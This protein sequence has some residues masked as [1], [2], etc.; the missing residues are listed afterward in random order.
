[1]KKRNRIYL[2]VN[3]CIDGMNYHDPAA[4]CIISSGRILAVEEERFIGIK[5][6]PGVF[7]SNALEWCLQE[8]G[9]TVDDVCCVAVPYSPEAAERRLGIEL[10]AGLSY[11]GLTDSTFNMTRIPEP[12]SVRKKVMTFIGSASQILA[13]YSRSAH[14]RQTAALMSNL[15]TLRAP[16]QFIPHHLAHAASAY[17]LAWP[18][19]ALV[20]VLDGVGEYSATSIFLGEQHGLTLLH[21]EPV[22]NSLGY[23]YASAT[24]FLGFHPWRDEGKTMAMAAYGK[25]NSRIRDALGQVLQVTPDGWQL[26]EFFC[27]LIHDGLMLDS[28][29][30]CNRLAELLQLKPMCADPFMSQAY[31]DFAWQVQDLLTNAVRSLVRRWIRKTDL[32]TVCAAGGVFLNSRMNQT[33]RE[34]KDVH[35]LLVQPVARDSGLAIGA[36]L[37]ASEHYNLLEELPEKIFW[38]GIGPSFN[39]FEVGNT[40][41]RCGCRFRQEVSPSEIACRLA[42]GEIGFYF[43]GGAEYGPRALG[44]RSI[45]AD[46]RDP[47]IAQRLNCDIKHREQWRPFACSMLEECAEDILIGYSYAAPYMIETYSVKTA[48]QKCIAGVVHIDGTTRPQTVN[49]TIQPDFHRLISAFRELTGV[50][51]VL[52]TSLNGR[53]QPL[54]RTPEEAL[55]LFSSTSASFL[56][57]EGYLVTK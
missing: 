8:C 47:G 51:L 16:V 38:P 45:L 41:K 44:H 36:A 10:A 26:G 56:Y 34:E 27:G 28:N 35:R 32:H 31:L 4:A 2:G 24:A 42:N 48:W 1:M 17:V 50:P 15:E 14:V 22:G 30:A 52:N 46:P 39:N 57:I 12:D 53:N 20:V 6:A 43:M 3:P 13:G 37:V 19:Q 25:P 54:V 40:L 49:A 23:F 18:R 11:A 55:A 7:P 5:S 33:L 9:A 29:R 21:E